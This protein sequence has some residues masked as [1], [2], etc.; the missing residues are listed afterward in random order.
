MRDRLEFR[1]TTRRFAMMA[2]LAATLST[3]SAT[4]GT[5]HPSSAARAFARFLQSSAP[6]CLRQPSA[7]CIALGWVYAD[8]DDDGRL[9][10]AELIA[11]ESAVREWFGWRGDDI[12]SRDR[13]LMAL[14]LW[15]VGWIGLESLAESYDADG[16][17]LITREE[18]LADI[19]LDERP[20]G[21]VLLD[22]EAVD[23]GAVASR[24]GAFAPVLG[25]FLK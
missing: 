14:G 13:I 2:C 25:T 12:P 20:L 22:A 10:A 19:R 15:I 18:L 17:G 7:A 16:D 5:A 8:V 21:Q 11:V 1:V 4:A 23:R 6:I 3:A 9:S 24:L